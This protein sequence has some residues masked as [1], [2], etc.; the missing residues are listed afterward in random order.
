MTWIQISVT[1]TKTFIAIA[2]NCLFTH[3]AQTITLSDAADQPILE[4]EPGQMPVWNKAVVTGLFPASINISETEDAIVACLQ[5]ESQTN[6]TT[7]SPITDIEI[8]HEIL[9]D[10]NWTRAWMNHYQPMQFGERLWVCPWHQDPPDKTAVNLRLD[11]G[12]AFGTGTHPTTALCLRWLDTNILQQHTLLDFGCGSGILAIAARL[13]GLPAVDCVD[14]DPQAL[15]ATLANAR[16]NQVEKNTLV[17][18]P[19]E[20]NKQ[21]TNTL[22][23]IIVANILSGPLTRLAPQLASH[24]RSGGDIVLSGILHEQ[25]ENVRQVYHTYF[26]MDAAVVDGDWV[27]LHGICR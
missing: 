4:P 22:Y 5:L 1:A 21:H 24:C 8:E 19:D 20:Y 16:A 27:L 25:A 15:Q 23:D 2:E 7:D 17:Y 26:A 3:G 13:L 12:L 9:E 14:I 6:L 11:P 10:Q 18:L